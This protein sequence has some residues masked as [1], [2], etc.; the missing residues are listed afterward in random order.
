MTMKKG[1]GPKYNRLAGE[2]RKARASRNEILE[3]NREMRK[4]IKD[5]EEDRARDTKTITDL[6][7]RST[8]IWQQAEGYASRIGELEALVTVLKHEIKARDAKPDAEAA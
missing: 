4:Q 6:S 1:S 8:A 2:L 3:A 7:E 5:L